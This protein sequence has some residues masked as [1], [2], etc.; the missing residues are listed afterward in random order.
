MLR[1]LFIDSCIYEFPIQLFFQIDLILTCEEVL[2]SRPIKKLFDILHIHRWNAIPKS[3]VLYPNAP[4][5]LLPVWCKGGK[6]DEEWT[7]YQNKSDSARSWIAKQ[8][9]KW[10]ISNDYR[11]SG[12]K[13]CNK[14]NPAQVLC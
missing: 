14:I 10:W 12:V 13:I 3:E 5:T 4:E 2:E 9:A 7:T 8:H 6:S 11:T 1:A